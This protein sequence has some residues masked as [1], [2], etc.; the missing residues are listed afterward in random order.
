MKRNRLIGTALCAFLCISMMLPLLSMLSFAEAGSHGL[1]M[2]CDA[3]VVNNRS[4]GFMIDF[5]SDSAEALGT[6]WAHANWHM[7]TLPSVR[8]LGYRSISGGGSY[9]GQQLRSRDSDRTCIMS[10]WKYEYR[11]PATGELH[12]LYAECMYGQSSQYHNE[13]SGTSYIRQYPWS[14]SRWYKEVLLCWEDEETGYT[15]VGTWL[16]DYTADEWT[17]ITYY[18]TFLVDSYIEGGCSQFLEN[19]SS[20]YNRRYRSWQYRNVYFLSHDNGVWVSSPTVRQFSDN[21]AAA[22]G[23]VKMGIASDGSYVWGSVDGT[24]EIDSDTSISNTYRLTQP[25]SPYLPSTAVIGSIDASDLSNV[26][27]NIPASA[28]PQVSYKLTVTDVDGEVLAVRSGTRP[29]VRSAEVTGV[30][31]DAYK[32]E[33][34]VTDIFGRRA[35]SSYTTAAYDAQYTGAPADPDGWSWSYANNTLTISGTG[36]MTDYKPTSLVPWSGHID[37]IEKVVVGSGVTSIGDYAF[38]G[39]ENLRTVSIAPTVTSIGN[40]AFYNARSL[41]K[42]TLPAG[43][44]EIGS[45]AFLGCKRMQSIILPSGLQK[46]GWN[47]FQRCKSLQNVYMPAG[48]DLNAVAIA[49][50]NAF[51][52]GAEPAFMGL[53]KAIEDFCDVNGDGS[54]TVS[55]LTSVL[56]DLSTSPTGASDLNGDGKSNVIDAT[57]LLNRLK[58]G[59]ETAAVTEPVYNQNPQAWLRW[60]VTEDSMKS[61]EDATYKMLLSGGPYNVGHSGCSE[62]SP[63]EFW[64]NHYQFL[65]TLSPAEVDC[66]SGVGNANYPYTFRI[67]YRDASEGGNYKCIDTAPWSTYTLSSTNVLYRMT[68]YNE[69]MN[70]LVLPT[71]E[72]SNEY[73]IIIVVYQG[74]TATNNIIGWKQDWIRYSDAT[75]AQIADA[76]A[77]GVIG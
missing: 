25:T 70:D 53:G 67:W 39:C 49:D 34:I 4:D 6:Y 47:A 9:T 71:G 59:P 16:Y 61:E 11:D 8:E 15:F 62:S 24:S 50:G 57:A 28:S 22:I 51:L 66:R 3:S 1:Y 13:G 45:C 37:D 12:D 48:G 58:N 54:V 44:T 2:E 21:N 26:T 27:W 69:G 18:N 31:T 35:T 7:Y 46:V 20:Y 14:N 41:K 29:D 5:Y 33:L 38:A 19:Y 72:T 55:D 76:R 68:T 60:L 40:Y 56:N 73:E 77:A 74:G 64:S 65:Y 63:W 17:L 32:C 30:S 52:T 10:C 42:I 75:E 23:E 36:A 43:I